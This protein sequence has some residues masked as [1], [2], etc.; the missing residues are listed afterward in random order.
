MLLFLS[1]RATRLR[2]FQVGI[3]E[4]RLVGP[5]FLS[6]VLALHYFSHCELVLYL[7]TNTLEGI[8]VWEVSAVFPQC[9]YLKREGESS[10]SI[11]LYLR[12]VLPYVLIVFWPWRSTP[13]DLLFLLSYEKGL[14]LCFFLFVS[15]T[16][17][18]YF[19]HVHYLLELMVTFFSPPLLDTTFDI[20]KYIILLQIVSLTLLFR[21]LPFF[22]SLCKGFF[23]VRASS[24]LL[25]MSMNA[26]QKHDQEIFIANCFD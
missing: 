9:V 19:L 14:F 12:W 8:L 22:P 4:S 10:L 5:S 16:W 21:M 25:P 3:H 18:L 24:Y 1:L 6:S 26:L 11:G 23:Y 13:I 2:L 17:L 7:L 15:Q 20:L